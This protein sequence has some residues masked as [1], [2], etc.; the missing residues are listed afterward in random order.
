VTFTA[1]A[2]G[3]T[4]LTGASLFLVLVIAG[5]RMVFA[6]TRRYLRRRELARMFAAAAV[7]NFGYRQLLNV[8]RT[9]GLVDLARK[10]QGWGE[11]RKRGLGYE[12]AGEPSG[13][14]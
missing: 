10:R 11:L 9:L 3:A 1:V 6:H 2:W 7:E 12:A 5:R 4:A 13:G 8:C 14:R